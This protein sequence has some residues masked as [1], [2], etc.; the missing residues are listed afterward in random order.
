[1]DSLL[2]ADSFRVRSN[3]KTGAA[4]V[5]GFAQHLDRFKWAALEAWCGP[6]VPTA[7]ER[8]RHAAALQEAYAQSPMRDRRAR[9]AVL[10]WVEPDRS[11]A[12]QRALARIDEFLDSV[13]ERIARFGEGWPRMEIGATPAAIPSPVSSY[14]FV[15]CPRSARPSICAPLGASGPRIRAARARTSRV[16]P[17]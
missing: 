15:R 14:D 2:V 1:M 3:P 16:T 9:A 17:S 13:P 8:A 12:E 4:E 5:R 7:D 6:H 11:P 10:V